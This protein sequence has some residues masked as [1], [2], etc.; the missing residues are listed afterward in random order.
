MLEQ[1]PLLLRPCVT[2]P[3]VAPPGTPLTPVR[4]VYASSGELLGVAGWR[5]SE[6]WSWLS[7][8]APPVLAVHENDDAPLLFTVHRR[9]GLGSYWE[10]RDADSHLVGLVNGPLLQDRLGRHLALCER[11]QTDGSVRVRDLDGRDLMTLTPRPAEVRLTFAP[12]AE[13]NPFLKMLLLAAA[14]LLDARQL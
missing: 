3:A 12:A 9:W 10:V 11:Q 2:F 5:M 4:A 7:W 8:L 1:S 13:A 14:L 6:W